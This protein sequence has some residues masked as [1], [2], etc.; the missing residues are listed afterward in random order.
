MKL[1]DYLSQGR[2]LI[3][4]GSMGTY[5]NSLPGRAGTRCELASVEHPEEI[6][7]IHRAY[8]DAGANAIKTNTFSLGNAFGTPHEEE[9][10]TL[11]RAACRLAKEAA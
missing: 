9:E 4:D 1:Q 8:L 10:V 2:P 7:S 3:F 5:Y 11:L 6:L